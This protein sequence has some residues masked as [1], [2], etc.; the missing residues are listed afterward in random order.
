MSETEEKQEDKIEDEIIETEE[1]DDVEK[2]A[3][4]Q[5]ED[6][7][8]KSTTDW[9]KGK[10]KGNSDE[11][12]STK[13]GDEDIPDAFSEA[14]EKEGWDA[15]TIIKHATE[16]NNGKPFTNAELIE[17]IPHLQKQVE[18]ET[19]TEKTGS[20]EEKKQEFEELQVE[21]QK[22]KD[23]NIWNTANKVF[24]EA[25]K[26]FPVFGLTKDLPVFPAGEN[27][28]ELI[29]TSP[30]FKARSEVFGQAIV[31]MQA[32]QN[33]DK[34][35]ANALYWYKGKNLEKDVERNV[36]KDLKKH[37]EQL[38]GSRVAKTVKKQYDSKRDEDIDYIRSLQRAQGQDV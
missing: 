34:S 29:P 5:T 35:M 1:T 8:F 18:T 9:I 31:N 28:G 10:M 4:E 22:Q 6:G 20:T 7:F 23:L 26:V 16:G 19:K 38:S 37:E 17:Q 24:D 2:P 30:Q 32:G 36:I 14:A 33:I 3:E 27:K 25:S 21:R 11:E 13:Q 12:D 15:A